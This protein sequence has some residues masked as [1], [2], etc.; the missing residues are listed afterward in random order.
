M[1]FLFVYDAYFLCL[2]INNLKMLRTLTW[3]YNGY[4][5]AGVFCTAYAKRPFH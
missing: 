3:E 4:L 5:G 2:A 1:P